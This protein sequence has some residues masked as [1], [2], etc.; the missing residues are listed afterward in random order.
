MTF[1]GDPPTKDT[2]FMDKV[3]LEFWYEKNNKV[4][5]DPSITNYMPLLDEVGKPPFIG[6]LLD[7]IELK[8]S[9]LARFE[10][11]QVKLDEQMQSQ[12]DLLN[13]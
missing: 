2:T 13:K 12:M 7:M 3:L 4:P 11:N 6:R 10:S 8:Q 5:R 1:S 9:A